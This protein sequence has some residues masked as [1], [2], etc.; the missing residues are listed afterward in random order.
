[1]ARAKIVPEK[2]KN[3]VTSIILNNEKITAKELK[4]AIESQDEF[5]R[6]NYSNKTYERLKASKQ[7]A[8]N[9]I[10]ASPLEE[11]WSLGLLNSTNKDNLP[12]DVFSVTPEA[13]SQILEAKK[14]SRTNNETRFEFLSIRQ[15]RWIA[16]LCEIKP[17][18]DHPDKLFKASGFYT[19]FEINSLVNHELNDTSDFDEALVEDTWEEKAAKWVL[20]KGIS[21]FLNIVFIMEGAK[22]LKEGE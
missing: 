4:N 19:F 20:D 10:K 17:L 12:A 6:Y 3:A 22:E 18:K 15:A 14:W 2:I 13:I 1:M 5:R 16:R 11:E 9:E 8:V 7:K 21:K